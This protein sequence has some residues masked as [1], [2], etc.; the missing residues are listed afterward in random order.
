MQQQQ[1]PQLG[2]F[3]PAGIAD[4]EPEPEAATNGEKRSARSNS[5]GPKECRECQTQFHNTVELRRHEKVH[6]KRPTYKCRKCGELFASIA[7]RQTHKNNK[8]FPSIQ[9]EV[10]NDNFEE[11]PR[12]T[13]LTARRNEQSNSFECPSAYCTFTTRIPSYWYDHIRKAEHIGGEDP[14]RQRRK[15]RKGK[16]PV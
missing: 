6:H 7:D 4:A 5:D 10:K 13:V 2:S 8:H 14:Q 9:Q 3:V 16:D 11:F 12:G 1:L 15:R